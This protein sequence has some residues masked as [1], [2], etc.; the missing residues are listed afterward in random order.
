ML[1]VWS[2]LFLVVEKEK[3]GAVVQSAPLA[4]CEDSEGHVMK[5][6]AAKQEESAG[7]HM[8]TI[9]DARRGGV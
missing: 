5:R 1:F 3:K 7:S 8:I 9:S 2:L 6:S 4:C